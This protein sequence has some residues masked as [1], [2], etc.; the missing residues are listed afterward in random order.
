[1]TEIKKS[2]ISL[3]ENYTYI[4]LLSKKIN[5]GII[6]GRISSYIK[7]K[8]FSERGCNVEVL[9][10]EFNEEFKEF[11]NKE[12]VTIINGNYYNGF[13]EKKH[14][15]II[16]LCDKEIRNKII[17]HCEE[18]C[19]LYLT[20]DD[21]KDGKF[22]TPFQR[23]T[24]TISYGINIKD[25]SPIT[26]RYLGEKILKEIKGKDDYIKFLIKVRQELK[27]KEEKKRVMEFLSSDDFYFFYEMGKGEIIYNLFF[28]GF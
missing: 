26:T 27:G 13:L 3:E 18:C 20:C 24:D 21:F 9:A 15:I 22:V 19:K 11:Y 10:K 16:A 17:E 8:T 12:N 2:N 1:M 14:L 25:A 6:G 5:V 4:A 28:G 23:E 7:C